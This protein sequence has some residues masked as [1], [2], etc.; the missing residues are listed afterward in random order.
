[1]PRGLKVSRPL[2]VNMFSFVDILSNFFMWKKFYRLTFWVA[3]W[4]TLDD[5]LVL[6]ISIQGEDIFLSVLITSVM[7]LHFSIQEEDI[8]DHTNWQVLFVYILANL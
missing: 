6:C 7:C 1:M 3:H 2:I 5:I 8:L 4:G